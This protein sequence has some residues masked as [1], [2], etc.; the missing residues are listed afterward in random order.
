MYVYE[1]EAVTGIMKDNMWSGFERS[2]RYKV[3]IR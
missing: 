3:K 1:G 2:E